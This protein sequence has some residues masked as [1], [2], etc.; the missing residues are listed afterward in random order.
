QAAFLESI[1]PLTEQATQLGS[2]C[3]SAEAMLRLSTLAHYEQTKES[4]P[5]AGVQV[6]VYKEPVYDLQKADEWTREHKIARIPERVIPEQL[7]RKAFDKIAR[8]TPLDFVEWK[9]E[10]QVRIATDL[11]KALA[12]AAQ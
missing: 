3:A 9:E 12:K 1:K 5:T 11:E 4:R 7:D 2:D 10:P 6:A 8:V